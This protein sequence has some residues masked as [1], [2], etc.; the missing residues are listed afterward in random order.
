MHIWGQVLWFAL[1]GGFV[2]IM[3]QAA[4]IEPG[5]GNPGVF[6]VLIENDTI[7]IVEVTSEPGKYDGWHSH[8][9]GYSYA[10][11]GGKLRVETP[12]GQTVEREIQTGD[13][14]EVKPVARHRALNIG[15]TTVKILLVEFKK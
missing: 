10:I 7:R 6:K 3:G 9:G 13:S 5:E 8:P 14:W 1:V 12:D 2:L 4:A 15:T 11:Q